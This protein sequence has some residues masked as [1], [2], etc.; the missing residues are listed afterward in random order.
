MILNR[1]DVLAHL[2]LAASG[3]L[4]WRLAHAAHSM[5][6]MPNVAAAEGAAAP[7]LAAPEP[8]LL[9]DAQ[10]AMVRQLTEMIIPQTDTPGAIQAGVPGFV[11][12]IVS[13]YYTEQERRIF[14][15]GL[16]ALD[17]HCQSHYG[18]A[19]LD[20]GAQQQ[21]DA[22]E[23]AEQASAGY[24]EPGTNA[25]MGIQGEPDQ[26]SPFFYKLKEMTVLGYYTSEVGAT[27]E[28]HYNPV[29]GRYD[30]EVS[31]AATGGRQWS[32]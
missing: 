31:F 22:L 23:A 17:Q 32:Y 27:T 2:T 29:P 18:K 12:H 15:E 24:R 9:N 26:A 13:S 14:I 21:A 28:L 20:S 3:V 1:R 6:G 5:A 30:G 10:R 11:D 8:S 25:S 16:V 7:L 4:G 19:F